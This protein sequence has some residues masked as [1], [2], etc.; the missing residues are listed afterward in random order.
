VTGAGQ[1]IGQAIARALGSAGAKVAVCDLAL[2]SAE[3]TVAE[4]RERG[5]EG[6]A[7]GVD[8][9]D[10]AQVEAMVAQA[11]QAFERIDIL[12]NNA[13]I[14]IRARLVE[15]PIEDWDRTIA[16]NLRGP[17]L[18]TRAVL[19]GMIAQQYGKI[20]NISSDSGKIGWVT[21]SAYCASKFG[22]IGMTESVALEV[23][24]YNINVNAICPG[25][26]DT[27]MSRTVRTEDG[28][29]YDTTGF[30]QPEDIA[31]VAVFLASDASRALYGASVDAFGRRR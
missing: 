3:A 22:V 5:I 13:G 20:I 31:D 10:P 26:V 18:C 19:P 7:I 17:F 1:G 27:P 24:K 16:V 9:T 8:V 28:Q 15:F 21:G 6:V 30:L 11:R 4:L 25:G 12:V 29:L 14:Q 23:A 2:S